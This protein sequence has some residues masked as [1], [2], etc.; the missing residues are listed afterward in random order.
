[1]ER[2]ENFELLNTPVDDFLKN[3]IHP[4]FRAL[5]EDENFRLEVKAVQRVF[6]LAPTF[7]AT[8][9]L[10]ADDLHSAQKIYRLGES[11][12]VRRYAD[13]P[14][15]TAESA[16][17]AWNRAADTHAAVLTVV[18]DL[19]ALEAEALPLALQN[20]SEALATFP[21]WNNLFKTGDLC[22]CEHCRSVLSPA[23]Y[24]AD[25]LMFLRDRQAAESR[26]HR[27]RIFSFSRR[28]DLGY[29]E[30][31]CDNAL[32]P[33]PYIDVVCEVL[34]DVVMQRARTTWS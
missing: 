8:D 20:D 25:L 14:G 22:E 16:R 2:H 30:L 19:K 31:N 15:F 24:F 34:E 6:K 10:L 4:E 27:S 33:L 3:S 9:A 28:P 11:E 13:R 21:N 1:M 17:L 26:P 18:A 32:T 7:E 5:A 29:L 12:F 23:A